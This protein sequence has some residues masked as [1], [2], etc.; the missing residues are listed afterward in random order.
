M[1][2]EKTA[3]TIETLAMAQSL[4]ARLCHDLGGPAGMAAAMLETVA[5]DAAPAG[6][7]QAEAM[8]DES[9]GIARDGAVTVR[10][11]LRVWRAACGGDTGSLAASE[12]VA[13]VQAM[14]VD[15]RVTFDC[16]LSPDTMLPPA[17]VQLALVGVM[18]GV[19]ALPRGG[20]VHLAG[21]AEELMVL[22]QGLGA[23]WPTGLTAAIAGM[24]TEADPR[25]VLAAFL[26]ALAL[27]EGWRLGLGFGPSSMP[28]PLTMT[29][30][31]ESSG[32][33]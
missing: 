16:A 17:A 31:G 21:G 26:A 4:C 32:L 10:A 33:K 15:S 25:R 24:P 13:L 7:G 11:R 5:A 22:P 3:A 27:A 9:L 1:M 23:R 30:Q 6:G 8:L 12:I 20:M 29:R 2:V 28:G 19:E 14:L 18:L